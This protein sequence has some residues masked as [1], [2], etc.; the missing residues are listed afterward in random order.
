MRRLL[1]GAL[2]GLGTWVLVAA[3]GG[4]TPADSDAASGGSGGSASGGASTGG[5]GG[6]SS[7][8]TGGNPASGGA[9]SGGEAGNGGAAGAGTGG[10]APLEPG[11][12][13]IVRRIALPGAPLEHI[14]SDFSGQAEPALVRRVGGKFVVGPWGTG[15]PYE[16]FPAWLQSNQWLWV[17]DDGS[18]LDAYAM[19][20]PTPP[21]G[22]SVDSFAFATSE[23]H[24]VTLIYGGSNGYRGG[25][26]EGDDTAPTI[27]SGLL[28]IEVNETFSDVLAGLSLD[29]Q[30]GLLVSGFG[31]YEAAVFAPDGSSVGD[32]HAELDLDGACWRHVPTAQS[33]AFIHGIRL[34]E[35]SAAGEMV[36]DQDIASSWDGTCTTVALADDGFAVLVHGD[37]AAWHMHRVG[38]DGSTSEEP[39]PELSDPP[40]GLAVAEDFSLVLAEDTLIRVIGTTSE[41]FDLPIRTLYARVITAEPGK[42]FL[43]LA[44]PNAAAREIVELGCAE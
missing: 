4:G 21:L 40:L 3:C 38:H 5:S 32:L 42:L 23:A 1:R 22:Y 44:N 7:G 41:E 20:I 36:L 19:A 25:Y 12:C 33:N 35:F 30:R 24:Q 6:S 8:G 15:E 10:T 34:K 17:S 31:G 9:A 39:W 2:T 43:D 11:T 29:G 28:E 18:E 26:A 16:Q 37:D 27:T 13:G 14:S